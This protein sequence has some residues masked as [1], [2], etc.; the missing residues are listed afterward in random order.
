MYILQLIKGN[1]VQYQRYFVIFIFSLGSCDFERDQ[2][3]YYRDMN[4]KNGNFRWRV[5]SGNTARFFDHVSTDHTT[6]TKHGRFSLPV[7]L[8]FLNP[9]PG[10]F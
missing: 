10:G 3:G 8:S 4:R 1:K 2:C 6:G 7:G 9:I 5:G